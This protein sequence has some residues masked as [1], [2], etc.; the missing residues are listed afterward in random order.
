VEAEK[1]VCEP[2]CLSSVLSA[3]I[4]EVAEFA[5]PRQV[6]LEC[7]PARAAFILGRHDLLVTALRGLLE[8][9]VKFSE[10]GGIVRLACDSAPDAIQIAIE[11]RGR[12]V[13][14]LAIPRFFDLFGIGEDSTGAGQLG[15]EPP[16]ARRILALFGGSV[17]IENRHPAGIQITA[18]LRSAPNQGPRA[19]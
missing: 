14:P 11:S 13:P 18:S 12:T 4:E 17:T 15:L 9:A 2:V 1:F 16:V 5:D 8:T 3:A 6:T 10:S 7:A 19:E